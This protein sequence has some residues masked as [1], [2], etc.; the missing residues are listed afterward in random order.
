MLTVPIILAALMLVGAILSWPHSGRSGYGPS[1]GRPRPA[2]SAADGASLMRTK[3]DGSM[4]NTHSRNALVGVPVAAVLA[5]MA[6][7]IV[8]GPGAPP[9]EGRLGLIVGLLSPAVLLLLR[10]GAPP[11]TVAKVRYTVHTAPTVRR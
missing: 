1:G 10:R 4:P 9:G 5:M 2:D 8:A 7:T 3:T 6:G 11:A